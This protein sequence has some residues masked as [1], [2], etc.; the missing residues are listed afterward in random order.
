M[1]T[2]PEKKRCVVFI[3]APSIHRAAQAAFSVSWPNFDPK[4]IAL[5]LCEA[6]GWEL[7]ETRLYALTPTARQNER[8]CG[9]WM[10]KLSAHSKDGVITTSFFNRISPRQRPIYDNHENIVDY[11]IAKV[12]GHEDLATKITI[13]AIKAYENDSFD[14]A[15]FVS[16]EPALI[17]VV[18]ELKARALE[19][20]VWIKLASATVFESG[21]LGF[22]GINETDWLHI[23]RKM[24][25]ECTDH[26]DYRVSSMSANQAV[27]TNG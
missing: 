5:A 9:F 20:D 7:A 8:W 19:D 27:N 25:F 1:R 6:N 26:R 22:R 10:N 24:Y 21:D 16:R 17:H 11:E 4:K 15:V 2:E 13:D 12:Y 23:N 14:V 18:R 3:D